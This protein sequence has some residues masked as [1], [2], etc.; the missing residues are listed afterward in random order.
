MLFPCKVYLQREN[1][2]GSLK[3]SAKTSIN[4]KGTWMKDSEK[5]M[6][7]LCFVASA[8]IWLFSSQDSVNFT[9]NYK[10]TFSYCLFEKAFNVILFKRLLNFFCPHY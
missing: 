6:P 1:L 2:G 5:F 8:Y 10:V 9:P 3:F 4:S 7:V